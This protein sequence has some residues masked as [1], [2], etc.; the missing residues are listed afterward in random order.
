MNTRVGEN[1]VRLSGGQRQRIA[2]ARAFYR[3]TKFLVL[4]EATSALDNITEH[5]LMNELR[6]IDKGLTILIIA[7]RISTI[8]DCDYVYEFENG[9]IKACG[10]YKDLIIN[11][12]SFKQLTLKK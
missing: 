3:D 10:T 11:S 6:E 4:D 8:K 12:A 1:G 9:E 5:N 7:H 2:I